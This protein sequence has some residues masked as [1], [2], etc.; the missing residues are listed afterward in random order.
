[1]LTHTIH[2]FALTIYSCIGILLTESVRSEEQ[3][4]ADELD[5][6]VQVA[7]ARMKEG[8][9]GLADL[10]KVQIA[11]NFAKYKIEEIS[12]DDLR[13]KNAPLEKKLTALARAA[14]QQKLMSTN[15]VLATIDFISN[16]R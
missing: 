8:T 4:I 1:M 15:D 6:I 10:L 13:K 11:T 16:H 7:D 14:Y 2:R 12:K 9:A 3:P 5:A